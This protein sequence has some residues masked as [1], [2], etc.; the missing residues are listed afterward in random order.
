MTAKKVFLLKMKFSVNNFSWT[1]IVV[2]NKWF[3]Q[4][5]WLRGLAVI[6]VFNMICKIKLT[7]GFEKNPTKSQ[8]RL[9]R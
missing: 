8:N 3:V 2:K 6:L 5:V 1:S 7:L 4:F 9:E